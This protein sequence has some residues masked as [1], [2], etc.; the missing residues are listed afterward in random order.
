M[1]I[2][3]EQVA[4]T[5]GYLGTH[6]CYKKHSYPRGYKH[7]QRNNASIDQVS[8]ITYDSQTNRDGNSGDFY[9]GFKNQRDISA[10]APPS[11]TKDY[12]N[13]IIALIQGTA[14]TQNIVHQPSINNLLAN[15]QPTLE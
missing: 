2:T 9:A 8:T 12:Y 1:G 5:M 7:K 4:H 11:F 13:I 6:R 14:P 10:V 3:N 15:F